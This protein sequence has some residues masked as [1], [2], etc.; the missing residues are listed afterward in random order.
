M[1]VHEWGNFNLQITS[2]EVS[3]DF[4]INV[5]NEDKPGEELIVTDS[6]MARVDVTFLWADRKGKVVLFISKALDIESKDG[7][8]YLLKNAVNAILKN[9]I[10]GMAI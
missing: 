4:K 1:V 3:E 2:I 10:Q 6:S 5:V 8:I 7:R 9:H